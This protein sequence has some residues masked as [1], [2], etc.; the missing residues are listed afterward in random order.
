[1]DGLLYGAVL[2]PV[3][4][5]LAAVSLQITNTILSQIEAVGR[6]FYAGVPDI[7][8]TVCQRVTAFT[9]QY[10]EDFMDRDPS[11]KPTQIILVAILIIGIATFMSQ[12]V[13]KAPKQ[14]KAKGKSKEQ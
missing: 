8:Q 12:P 5:M 7:L 1:M 11:F 3:L 4:L 13:A 10:L 6:G 14:K 2:A 9:R